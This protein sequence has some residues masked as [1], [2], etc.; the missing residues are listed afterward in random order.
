MDGIAM[1]R[2]GIPVGW[3]VGA[4]VGE[5]CCCLLSPPPPVASQGSSG[6]DRALD[7]SYLPWS[8]LTLCGVILNP[9]LFLIAQIGQAK[10]AFLLLLAAP[11]PNHFER[12]YVHLILSE[13]ATSHTGGGAG[14]KEVH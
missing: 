10:D 9:S 11:F 2:D 14:R 4:R 12:L 3:G 8:D 7:Y 13:P 5:G 6:L 1:S